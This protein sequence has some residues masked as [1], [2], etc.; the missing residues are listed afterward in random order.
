M[1]RMRN[2][3]T[4]YVTVADLAQIF[5]VT[6]RRIRAI[7][8]NRG[9]VGQRVGRMLMYQRKFVEKFRPLPCGNR[10]SWREKD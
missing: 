2:I 8:A 9:I 1:F 5:G 7:A 6:P 10:A 4:E 3:L